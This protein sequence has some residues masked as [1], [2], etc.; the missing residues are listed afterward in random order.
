[1]VG[2][3]EIPLREAKLEVQEIVAEVAVSPLTVIP[4]ILGPSVTATVDEPVTPAVCWLVAVTVAEATFI[5][6]VRRPAAV[7][8]PAVV[9]QV[10]AELKFPIP[11]TVAAHAEV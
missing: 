2:P 1:M 6:A 7:I 10:T 8:V 5:G 11:V 9:D 4:E 3:Y